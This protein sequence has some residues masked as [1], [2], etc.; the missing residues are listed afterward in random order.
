LWVFFFPWT[1]EAGEE[2]DILPLFST[3]FSFKKTLTKDPY[4]PKAFHVLEERED[5][6]ASGGVGAAA[7]RPPRPPYPRAIDWAGVVGLLFSPILPINTGEK[8][9]KGGERKKRE[10]KE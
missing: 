6:C 5:K 4:L 10:E 7:Q 1:R 2:E 3:A 8:G 9:D